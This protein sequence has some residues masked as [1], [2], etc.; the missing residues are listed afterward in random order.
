MR[1]SNQGPFLRLRS[2]LVAVSFVASLC[3][4]STMQAQGPCDL[5]AGQVKPLIQVLRD[6][7]LQKKNPDRVRQAITRLAELRCAAAAD[8]LASL[9]AF[10]YRFDWEGTHIRLQ[11]IFTQSRYPATSALT[12]IG[13]AS[14]PA[15]A[16]VIE[17]N[18]PDS[19]MTRNATYTVK[20]IFRDHPDKAESYRTSTAE[21]A[22]TPESQSRL[23]QAAAALPGIEL[24]DFKRYA[25]PA[26]H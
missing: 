16:K 8:D 15:L 23:R 1:Q 5:Q 24:M 10:K 4:F 11:P 7:E 26:P 21:K 3:G 25:N 2:W 22:P 6:R 20:S 17:E 9:L 13:E 14:L 12:K 19:L 18:P